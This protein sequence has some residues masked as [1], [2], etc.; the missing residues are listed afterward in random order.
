M[1]NLGTRGIERAHWEK[2]VKEWLDCLGQVEIPDRQTT[3]AENDVFGGMGEFCRKL[4]QWDPNI[5]VLPTEISKFY[6]DE[7]SGIVHES[8]VEVLKKELAEAVSRHGSSFQRSVC[9]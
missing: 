2:S 4:T 5:L 9:G 3:V 7:H 6:M 1:F 8:I